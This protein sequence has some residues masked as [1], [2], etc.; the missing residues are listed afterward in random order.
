LT[1]YIAGRR[2]NNAINYA[3]AAELV[4]HR[5]FETEIEAVASLVEYIE[6]YNRERLHSALG[7]QSPREYEKLC[8]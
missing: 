3:P 2:L 1:I 5:L 7:Y 6:F 8:A 4:H